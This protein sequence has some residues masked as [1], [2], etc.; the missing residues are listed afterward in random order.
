MIHSWYVFH[1]YF[2]AKSSHSCFSHK[3]SYKFFGNRPSIL[4]LGME[5]YLWMIS[6]LHEVLRF[7]MRFMWPSLPHSMDCMMPLLPLLH[8][9]LTKLDHITSTGL[10]P[11]Y[12]LCFPSIFHMSILYFFLCFLL[13]ISRVVIIPSFLKKEIVCHSTSFLSTNLYHW[14]LALWRR[15]RWCQQSAFIHVH[16]AVNAMIV[17]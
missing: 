14:F 6:Y 3:L 9:L 12:L 1:S 17:Y 15:F 7:G 16:S 11:C 8:W 5:I 4:T 10:C 2:I 13:T